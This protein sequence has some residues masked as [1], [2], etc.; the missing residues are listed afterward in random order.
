[1]APAGPQCSMHMCEVPLSKCEVPSS[2]PGR[3]GRGPAP[4]QADGRCQPIHPGNSLCDHL[5]P[6]PGLLPV[7]V[8]RHRG[9]CSN[10]SANQIPKVIVCSASVFVCHSGQ[11]KCKECC[12]HRVFPG[13]AAA[14]S[15]D[16]GDREDMVNASGFILHGRVQEAVWRQDAYLHWSSWPHQHMMSSD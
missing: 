4:V 11:H 9:V 2:K 8:R 16:L 10:S 7:K 1:M 6:C 14:G 3:C 5:Q 12:S 15:P 13:P